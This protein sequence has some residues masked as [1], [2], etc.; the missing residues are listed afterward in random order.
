[1]R[2]IETG[3]TI[4]L[5]TYISIGYEKDNRVYVNQGTFV[6]ETGKKGPLDVS[7]LTDDNYLLLNFDERDGDGNVL[8][9]P[10]PIVL[11]KEGDA[12]KKTIEHFVNKGIK[13]IN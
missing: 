10:N 8:E 9:G 6:R 12:F 1:M 7:K 4:T 13:K 11:L 5:D 3:E 2:D